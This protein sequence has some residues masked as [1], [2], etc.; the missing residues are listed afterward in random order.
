MD[1]YPIEVTEKRTVNRITLKQSITDFLDAFNVERGLIYTIHLLFAKP[2]KLI[3]F[4]LTDG[5]FKIVNAFRLLIISTATSLVLLNITGSLSAIYTAGEGTDEKMQESLHIV[6]NFMTEWYNLVLWASIPA[7]SIFT[8]LLFR[9]NEKMNYAE[10]LVIQSFYV[11]ASNIVYIGFTPL[12]FLFGFKTSMFISTIA[13]AVFYYYL[14]FDVFKTTA[15]S[16]FWV[17]VKAFFSF[18]LGFMIYMFILAVFFTLV[19]FN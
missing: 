16:K 14:Y 17:L 10:H 15:K 7:F 11:S 8:F 6:G 13:T 12:G 2:G 9:K 3:R 5:R 4:Y 19:L 1:N 18:V